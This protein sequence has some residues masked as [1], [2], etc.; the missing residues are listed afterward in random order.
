MLEALAIPVLECPG[1]EADDV[2]AT[3]AR[4]CDEAGAKCFIV[5]GD[6]DCRQLITDR[7][8]VYNIR[9]DEVFD[10]AA[11]RRRLGHRARSGRRL[12]GARGRQGR[13]RAGRAAHRAEDWPRSCSK[14]TARSTTCSTT[15][16][17]CPARRAEKLIEYRE[18]ALLS[19]KLVGSIAHVPIAPRL[20]RRPRRRLRPAARS[21]SCSATSASARSATALAAIADADVDKLERPAPAAVDAWEADYQIVDTPEELDVLV[22]QLARAVA[23]LGRHRNDPHLAALRRDRRLLVRLEAGRGVLRPRPRPGGRPRARP[24]RDARRAAAGPRKP[25]HR[26]DRPEPE[27]R[28]DRAPQRRHRAARRGVRHDVADYLL[29]AGERSHNLDDLAQKYLDHD[30]DQD[31]ASSS[32]KGKNQ[33]RMDE[34]PVAQSAR[35]AAEDADIPLRLHADSRSSG[36][37]RRSSTKLNETSKCR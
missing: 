37:P 18:A 21:P 8:A 22:S 17:K 19:R 31:R 27:V 4:L 10:A 23:D 5:T 28:H 29:D 36:S 14:H 34:V 11:L 26:Q 9:K 32:A 13:Q 2:L 35:Y 33:K 30:D 20:G 12:P 6:K 24:R 1:Y 25:G 3:L 7:V 15:P 16:T